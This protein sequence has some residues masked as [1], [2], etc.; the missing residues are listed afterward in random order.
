MS[1]NATR[2]FSLRFRAWLGPFVKN[3]KR[4]RILFAV[5]MD[6]SINLLGGIPSALVDNRWEVHLVSNPGPELEEATE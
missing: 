3:L 5:T 6:Y 4:R 2:H 1:K